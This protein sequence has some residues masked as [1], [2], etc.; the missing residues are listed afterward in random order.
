MG[1]ANTVI[2]QEAKYIVWLDQVDV[3][4]FARVGSKAATLARLSQAGFPV[5]NGFCVTVEACGDFLSDS[6]LP[7]LQTQ[8]SW[9]YRLLCQRHGSGVK[10][11]VRSSASLEDLP[12]ASFAGQ[13]TSVLN[14]AG[15]SDLL[16]AIKRCCASAFSPSVRAYQ[17]QRNLHDAQIQMAVIVQVMI[18][19]DFAGVLF[20]VDP[21]GGDRTRLVVEMTPGLGDGVASGEMM[22]LHFSVDRRDGSLAASTPSAIQLADTRMD[23]SLLSDLALRIE[24]LFQSPQDIEWAYN[25]KFWILQ[26]R[27]ITVRP[28]RT[29]RQIWTRANAGEIMPEVV[30]PLTWSIFK[31]ILQAAG[32]H[33]SRLPSMIHWKWRHPCGDWPDSPRLFNGRAYMEL[34]SVYASFGSL[35]G[36]TPDMLRRVLGFEFHLCRE[37]ELPCKRPR[38][39]V[40]DPYRGARFWLEMLGIT[41]TLPRQARRWLHQ[42]ESGSRASVVAIASEM[43]P[44]A[45]LDCIARLLREAARILGLHI[46][47]TSMAFSAFGLLDRLVQKYADPE[48]ARTF[49]AEL[50]ADFQSIT[51]VQQGIAIWD[52]AQAAER[53]PQVRE[54][55]FNVESAD[56]TIEAWERYPEAIGFMEL[57]DSFIARFGDR[58]TQEFELA[59]AH[60]DE[61]PSF[62]LQTMREILTHRRPNPRE[63]LSQQRE[64]GQRCVRRMMK[65]VR[66]G[67]SLGDTWLFR[68]LIA[69]YKE[70]VSLRENLKY[71]VISRFNS[72]R[73][74]FIASGEVL[75]QRSLISNC[76]DI[77]FLRYDEILDLLGYPSQSASDVSAL[78]ARRK[79]EREEY[80][81]SPAADVWVSTDGRELPVELPVWQ[82]AKVLQGIGCSPGRIAGTAR[83]LTLVKQDTAVLPGQILVTPSIDPG[84]TPLFLTAAGLVTE[85]G[86][87]LSHGATVAREYGLPAVVGVPHATSIIRN[88][89]QITVDGFTGLVH[90]GPVEG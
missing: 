50:V 29:C 36:V 68:R 84:L 45:V 86:G 21:L 80:T 51:T 24:D 64:A 37:D 17:A 79:S 61:D 60:W 78:V 4:S 73:K 16:K 39:H 88:G 32:L 22:P 7:G 57:W 10:V 38:W 72:L 34:A 59:V 81:R 35:P 77:F 47:C 2:S 9:A 30:S 40:M 1:Q 66:S 20:T 18:P 27:P 14:V 28:Q 76:D 46:H 58:G 85:V 3:G 82:D 31:P 89:Q 43:Q 23:W 63:R 26:S 19:A 52:L 53:V 11:A 5:P 83:V 42:D 25:E 74:L 90:L 70:Y 69:A 55:L 12:G 44:Q 65:R 13:Y 62:V 41:K 54:I 8:V 48:D 6:L 75:V 33:R 49:E 87:V 67:G 71:C 56:Q 15:E